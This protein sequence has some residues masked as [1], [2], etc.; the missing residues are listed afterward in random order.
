MSYKKSKNLAIGFGCLSLG[1]VAFVVLG[2]VFLGPLAP[3]AVIIGGAIAV[4]SAISACVF[5]SEACESKAD[6]RRRRNYERDRQA[7]PN[8][9]TVVV[10]PV[11]SVV[12]APPP[13]QQCG[14]FPPTPDPAVVN[15]IYQPYQP[16]HVPP[17]VQHYVETPPSLYTAVTNYPVYQPSQPVQVPPPFTSQFSTPSESHVPAA[18]SNLKG[19]SSPFVR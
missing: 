2:A 18:F 10:P 1:A 19:N 16:V 14:E 9:Q 11:P 7:E 13:V 17:P 15:P 4:W 5:A 3:A 6:R 12:P 8:I